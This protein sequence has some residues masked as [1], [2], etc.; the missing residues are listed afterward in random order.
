MS[1]RATSH[2]PGRVLTGFLALAGAALL[3]LAFP[4]SARAS[5]ALL[6]NATKQGSD[7]HPYHWAA[8]C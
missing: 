7:G 2:A 3:S 8:P 5:G 4:T 1:D 6:A